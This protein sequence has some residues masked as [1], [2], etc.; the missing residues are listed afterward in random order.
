MFNE[1]R[2]YFDR[3][4]KVESWMGICHGWAAAFM[5][6]R[7]KAVVW[8][9]S[10]DGQY[11]IPFYPADIKSLGSLLYAKNKYQSTFIGGRCNTK[12][13]Q[14][15]ANGR[16]IDQECFDNNPAAW[17][18][19]VVNQIGVNDRSMVLDATYDYEVWNQPILSYD[20]RYFNPESRQFTANLESAKVSKRN[21]RSDKFTKYRDS[22]TASMVGIQMTIKYIVE[23]SPRQTQRDSEYYDGIKEVTY[24]YDLELD[25]AGN[26]ISASGI[27]TFTQT[28]YGRL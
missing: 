17:H 28:S 12:D 19:A 3:S 13:P 5:L 6:P 21:Y 27:Q 2:G 14:Q 24:L 26:V 10:A 4:G 23:T 18:F 7:P 16:T 9:K 8:V 22:R 15:D 20:I 11:D 1:G 25:P